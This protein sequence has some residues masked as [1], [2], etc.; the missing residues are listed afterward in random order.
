MLLSVKDPGTTSFSCQTG[1]PL[2]SDK[3]ATVSELYTL[4]LPSLVSLREWSN[5]RSFEHVKP[6]ILIR[7]VASFFH[8]SQ[9]G[10]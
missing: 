1:N 2:A 7:K 4:Q 9:D 10:N 3:K 6:I 5:E 8:V